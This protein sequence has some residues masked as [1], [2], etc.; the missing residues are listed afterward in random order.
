MTGSW[1]FNTSLLDEKDFQAKR[2]QTLNENW[3]M[4]WLK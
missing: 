4:P 1:K 3:Q 2:L